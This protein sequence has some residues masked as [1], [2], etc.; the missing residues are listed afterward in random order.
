[1]NKIFANGRGCRE[2]KYFSDGECHRFPP[3][4]VLWP[5]HNLPPVAYRPDSSFPAVQ[6]HYWCGEWEVDQ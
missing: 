5:D 3:Q 2:C 1:M 6:P 4:M